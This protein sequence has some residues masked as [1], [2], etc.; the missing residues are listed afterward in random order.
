MSISTGLE[1]RKKNGV[2]SKNG[3][4]KQMISPRTSF[5]FLQKILK[6]I[7]KMEFQK[8][9]RCTGCRD[10]ILKLHIKIIMRLKGLMMSLKSK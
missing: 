4:E 7:P 1:I 2:F 9:Q 8:Y 6:D 10:L 3:E 5:I